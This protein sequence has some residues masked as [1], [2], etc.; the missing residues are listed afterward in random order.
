M[1]TAAPSL[2]E[3]LAGE[4]LDLEQDAP[5]RIDASREIAAQK[6]R[7]IATASSY[8]AGR[9]LLAWAEERGLRAENCFQELAAAM[10]AGDLIAMRLAECWYAQPDCIGVTPCRHP[11]LATGERRSSC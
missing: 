2:I 3:R 6:M 7:S 9:G 10:A 1:S 11:Q 4:Q 5:K 8:R